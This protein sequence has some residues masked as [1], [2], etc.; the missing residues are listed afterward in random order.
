MSGA[1]IALQTMAGNT[2]SNFPRTAGFSAGENQTQFGTY[3]SGQAEPSAS[4]ASIAAVVQAA[5]GSLSD[6]S[7]A[8]Y[9][10]INSAGGPA[11]W[12]SFMSDSRRKSFVQA[13]DNKTL[14][15]QNASNVSGLGRVD[16]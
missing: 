5:Q 8:F 9:N 12:A 16:G 4:S 3:G 2:Y 14:P 13:F 7:A 15:V 6:P 10:A 1:E 11:D